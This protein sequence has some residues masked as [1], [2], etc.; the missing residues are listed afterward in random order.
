MQEISLEIFQSR[1]E[2]ID[3]MRR[4]GV[5]AEAVGYGFGKS[6]MPLAGNENHVGSMYLGAL[7]VLAEAGAAMCGSTIIDDQ[8]HF[9]IVRSMNLNFLK[10]AYTDVCAE[11]QLEDDTIARLLAQLESAGRSEYTAEFDMLDDNGLTVAT[12]VSTITLLTR[13]DQAA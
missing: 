10:P 5:R 7:S 13:R 6:R 9:P 3:F 11:Y 1:M 8:R 12:V 2:D 4:C